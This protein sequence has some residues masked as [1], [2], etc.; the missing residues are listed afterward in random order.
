MNKVGGKFE[1]GRNF[2]VFSL[3]RVLEPNDN[4]YSVSRKGNRD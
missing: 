3:S 2:G 4:L 1:Y